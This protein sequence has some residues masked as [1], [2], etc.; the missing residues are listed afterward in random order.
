MMESKYIPFDWKHI[1]VSPT[2]IIV[3]ETILESGDVMLSDK[4]R[5]EL[6]KDVLTLQAGLDVF[7]SPEERNKTSF[8]R[9]DRRIPD[10]FRENAEAVY[11]SGKAATDEQKRIAVNAIKAAILSLSKKG[12]GYENFAAK[13]LG[14]LGYGKEFEIGQPPRP[15]TIVINVKKGRAAQFIT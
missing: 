13:M 2:T 3:G 14:E 4:S 6:H 15:E 7:L 11:Q 8:F 1:A 10:D 12:K 9:K 5:K